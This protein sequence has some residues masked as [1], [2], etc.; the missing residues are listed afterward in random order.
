MFL[1]GTVITEYQFSKLLSKA[2]I[3]TIV[4]SSIFSVFKQ[5]EVYPFNPRAV[6]NHDPCNGVNTT[7]KVT[8]DS[9][10]ENQLEEDTNSAS[11][12]FMFT[13]EELKYRVL[14]AKGYYL[15][16]LKYICCLAKVNYLEEESSQF[17]YLSENP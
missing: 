11:V 9:R 8:Q 3:N 15:Y 10:G 5:C 17:L 6:L 1:P 14:F 4:P 12:S 7:D 16:D 2:W 13:A